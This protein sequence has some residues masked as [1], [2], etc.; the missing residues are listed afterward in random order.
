MKQLY[1]GA[2]LSPSIVGLYKLSFFIVHSNEWRELYPKKGRYIIFCVTSHS[3]IF[4]IEQLI[5]LR[6]RFDVGYRIITYTNKECILKLI[7]FF[8]KLMRCKLAMAAIR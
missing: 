6:K 2:R 4:C 8:L 1:N 3:Y 7:Q 5:L